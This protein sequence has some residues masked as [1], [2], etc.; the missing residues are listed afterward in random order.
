MAKQ[1]EYFDKKNWLQRLQE[2]SWEPEILISGIVLYGL[3]NMFPVVDDLGH[4]LNNY[5]LSV[6]SRGTTGDSIVALLKISIGWLIAGF[7]SHLL[8]R[9]VWAAYIGL[10]YIYD[11]QTNVDKFKYAPRFKKGIVKQLNYRKQIIRLEK[12]SSSLFALSFLIF[13]NIL[14]ITFL[15]LMIG[16]GVYLWIRFF[17]ERTD[18]SIFNIILRTVMLTYLIDYLSLGLLKR[19]PYLNKV[20]Y[21]FYKLMSWL[22]LSPLYRNIY[23]GFIANHKRWKVISFLVLFV[24]ITIVAEETIRG[25]LRSN[26]IFTPNGTKAFVMQ[27]QHYA[28]QAQGDHSDYIWIPQRTINSHTLKA[29]VVHRSTFEEDDIKKI[30]DFD[31]QKKQYLEKVDSLKLNC[32]QQFYHLELDQEVVD[33][34][35]YYT[36]SRLSDQDGLLHY[37]DISQLKKGKH[38]LRLY[39]NFYNEDKDTIYK[40]FRSRVGFYKTIDKIEDKTL[41]TEFDQ[42]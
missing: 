39:F 27:P 29:F 42:E 24:I 3:F 26:L 20:Y 6:F 35:V 2:G 5:G 21:P 17:P 33:S 41:Q 13:M 40:R 4:Y 38:E 30:C 11:D 16:I 15:V 10:T 28:S 14:G 22:L 31:H 32:L 18:F 19:I 1:E 12:I 7:V 8:F 37:I 34:P 25:R 36:K 9:S 23:Y